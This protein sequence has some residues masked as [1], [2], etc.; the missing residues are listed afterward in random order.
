MYSSSSKFCLLFFF[1]FSL[2]LFYWFGLFFDVFCIISCFSCSTNKKS[3]IWKELNM[4]GHSLADTQQ[5]LCNLFANYNYM[6]FSWQSKPLI[7]F[8]AM[9]SWIVCLLCYY[10]V[11]FATISLST[12]HYDQFA[13]RVVQNCNSIFNVKFQNN[14]MKLVDGKNKICKWHRMF[15]VPDESVGM[16]YLCSDV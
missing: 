8:H 9:R 1:F 16:K 13:W 2:P 5:L 4:F 6:P 14:I 3:S 11:V 12:S 7:C 15:S 10:F